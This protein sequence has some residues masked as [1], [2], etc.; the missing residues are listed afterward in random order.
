MTPIDLSRLRELESRARVL[1][2]GPTERERAT[3]AVLERAEAVLRTA[4][5]PSYAADEGSAADLAKLPIRAEA[6]SDAFDAALDFVSRHV[7]LH[8]HTAWGPGFFGYIPG[9][10]QYYAAL[11]DYM[12]AVLNPFTGHLRGS[13]GGVRIENQVLDWLA[14]VVGYP[15]A[16][17]GNLTS[18]GSLANLTALITAREAAGIKSR[19]VDRTVVYLSEQVHHCVTKGL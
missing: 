6:G 3:R 1:E 5:I 2:L 15:P 16:A 10:N 7:A 8:G 13:P 19:D 17:T 9:G 4:P 18:G 14:S 11:G 12:A